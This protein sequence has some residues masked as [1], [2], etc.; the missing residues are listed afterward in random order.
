MKKIFPI[1]SFCLI[2]I[3]Y[4][5][6]NNVSN[7]NNIKDSVLK[8]DLIIFHAGSLSLPIKKISEEFKKLY[9]EVNIM[10]EASG[11]I[12]CARKITE[13]NKPC[14]II[15]SAD[16]T[17]IDKMLIPE[18]ASW[19]IK[20]ASNEMVIA[21]TEKSL[22]QQQ[23]NINN[24]FDILLDAKVLIGRSDPN[25]DPCGYRTVQI[26]K[27]ADMFYKQTLSHKI[28]NKNTENIRPK[29]VDLL[30]LL[31]SHTIDYI[32]IYRS[33]AEQHKLKYIVLPDEINLK[34]AELNSL[35][36]TV[37]VE[38]NGKKPGE[39]IVQ[40]GEAMVYGVSILKKSPNYK[41]ALAF[42][43]F[44]LNQN[45]GMKIMTELGQPSII[46]SQSNN[47]DSIPESLKMYAKP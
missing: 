38:V 10:T 16:Y 7:N 2:S 34:N 22:K 23:I 27:L 43:E 28:L 8:G 15:A 42:I 39:K 17:V 33:V 31:E 45:Y 4:S 25:S 30:A 41:V 11:S 3:L 40:K 36:N 35:Y 32:F 5:C 44:M 9:P 37:E 20:F 12:E 1:I 47:Y 6:Q 14:D 24:W 29:E 21:F 13:L 18:Y 19:N 46:P 26:L